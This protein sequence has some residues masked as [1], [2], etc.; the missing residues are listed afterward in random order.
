MK[1]D[2]LKYVDDVWSGF[3]DLLANLF[4]RYASKMDF[5]LLRMQTEEKLRNPDERIGACIVDKL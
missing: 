2:D 5:D 3:A 4:A 1:N